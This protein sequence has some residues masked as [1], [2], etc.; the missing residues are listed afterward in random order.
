MEKGDKVQVKRM[1]TSFDGKTG[2]VVELKGGVVPLVRVQIDGQTFTFAE[3]NL[4]EADC[5]PKKGG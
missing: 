5:A 4:M 2:E 3:K 1:G